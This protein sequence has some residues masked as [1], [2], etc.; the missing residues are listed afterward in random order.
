MISNIRS[1]FN[2]TIKS[3][4][5]DLNPVKFAL[6]GKLPDNNIEDTFTVIFGDASSDLI[7]TTIDS[8]IP[9]TVEFWK[10]GYTKEIENFDKSY[11][12]A[13]DIQARALNKRLIADHGGIEG[14]F[15]SGISVESDSTN[16]NLFKFTIQFTVKVSYKDI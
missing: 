4:D 12:K 14:V 7:D 10:N 16:D 15:S 8:L 5:S 6:S 3:I 11:C 9:V 1:Y 2:K 13:V